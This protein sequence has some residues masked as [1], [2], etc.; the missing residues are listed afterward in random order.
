LA[1]SEQQRSAPPINATPPRR[2]GTGRPI[3][4]VNSAIRMTIGSGTPRINSNNE[5]IVVS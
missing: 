5:R 2:C 3:T 4:Y 1:A